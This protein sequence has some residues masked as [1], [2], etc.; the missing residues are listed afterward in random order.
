M[1]LPTRWSIDSGR[2]FSAHSVFGPCD[3][4]P[5][6]DEPA[7]AGARR[8][9]DDGRHRRGRG[10]G[11]GSGGCGGRADHVEQ[12]VLVDDRS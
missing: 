9:G 1:P 2:Y 6:D 5:D 12:L 3:E 10:A 11:S 4:L 8:R 7:A